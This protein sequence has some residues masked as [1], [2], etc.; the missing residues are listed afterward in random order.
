M[1]NRIAKTRINSK[2]PVSEDC[3]ALLSGIS[4]AVIILDNKHRIKDFTPL[5]GKYFRLRKKDI[6]VNVF[7]SPLNEELNL[8]KLFRF[9]RECKNK[10]LE[11]ETA[12]GKCFSLSIKKISSRKNTDVCIITF[13]DITAKKNAEYNL[14]IAKKDFRTLISLYEYRVTQRTRKL[15]EEIT[16]RKRIEAE[17]KKNQNLYMTILENYPNGSITLFD[18][19]L[20]V[21]LTEGSSFKLLGINKYDYLGKSI[22]EFMEPKLASYM[23][24]IYR[25]VFA[26]KTKNTEIHVGGHYYAI[27]AVPVRDEN[28]K[29]FGCLSFTRN[30]SDIK[31]TE[32][33]RQQITEKLKMEIAERK[34]IEASQRVLSRHLV[35]AQENERLKLS[36]EL[37]DGINQLL[38]AVKLKLHSAEDKLPEENSH[39]AVSDL[40]DAKNYLERVITEVRNLS[41]NLRPIP[42]EDTG[43]N[44]ALE[45][46]CN[47]FQGRT[48][49]LVKC[50]FDEPAKRLTPEIELT[51]YRIVQE[52]IH[53]V[54]KHA[55]ARLV[56][57]NL[58][59]VKDKIKLEIIDDG[60]GFDVKFLR[61]LTQK[62]LKELR[63]GLIGMR[64]RVEF[65]KGKFNIQSVPGNGTIITIEIPAVY[66]EENER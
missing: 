33:L 3:K 50:G 28:N 58:K 30:I 60:K 52:A 2:R 37:H 66:K 26:G 62:N 38:S 13:I 11:I 41:K 4:S 44:L 9:S 15:E 23:K 34:S 56:K 45:S 35:R 46:L 57:V 43:I 21:L 48:G 55:E 40:S 31:Q 1:Y 20:R 61:S 8:K 49:V 5:A 64:E 42:L 36:H 63:M 25:S 6:G 7:K 54:E 39:G 59:L 22:S 53:N 14:A 18:R 16:E 29:I 17:I 10:R 27:T 65:I 32:M 19:N 47:E 12:R 51:L 24:R